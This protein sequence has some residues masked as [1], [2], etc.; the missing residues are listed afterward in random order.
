[1]YKII[2]VLFYSKEIFMIASE[3]NLKMQHNLKVN[4]LV[5]NEFVKKLNIFSKHGKLQKLFFFIY[6]QYF[7]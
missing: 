5:V 4:K 7:E 1:M 3:G 6:H 2:K